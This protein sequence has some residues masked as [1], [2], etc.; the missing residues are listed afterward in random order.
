MHPELELLLGDHV[1]R[2]DR[3]LRAVDRVMCNIEFVS[4]SSLYIN[5]QVQQQNRMEAEKENLQ[6]RTHIH[7]FLLAEGGPVGLVCHRVEA[8]Q[9]HALRAAVGGGRAGGLQLRA[10]LVQLRRCLVAVENGAGADRDESAEDDEAC[11]VSL[12]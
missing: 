11:V 7:Q 2:V 12:R 8:V 4:L 1:V 10:Q 9:A 3:P 5:F 6:R